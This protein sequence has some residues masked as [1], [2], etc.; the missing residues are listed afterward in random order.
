MNYNSQVI[1]SAGNSAGAGG[2]S[3]VAEAPVTLA[4]GSGVA[5][6]DVAATNYN[7]LA[8]THFAPNCTY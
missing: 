7:P 2:V 1:N 4:F 5:C 8:R 6:K 3:T